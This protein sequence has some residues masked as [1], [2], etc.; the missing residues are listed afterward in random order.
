MVSKCCGLAKG[1]APRTRSKRETPG[2]L[3]TRQAEA[4]TIR[5]A[6][7]QIAAAYTNLLELPTRSLDALRE[8]GNLPLYL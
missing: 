2:T 6:H 5:A 4:Q 7:H 8:A 3:V 1:K